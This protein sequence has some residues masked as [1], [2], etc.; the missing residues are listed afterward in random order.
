MEQ[1]GVVREKIENWK[2]GRE[3]QSVKKLVSEC[4]YFH[5][6]SYSLDADFF[7]SNTR[8]NKEKLRFYTLRS[9]R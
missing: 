4:G 9:K 2:I 8:V 7:T 5:K 6:R 1:I 3:N